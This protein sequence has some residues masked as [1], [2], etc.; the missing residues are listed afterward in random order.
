MPEGSHRFTVG[1]MQCT[2]LT[3]GYASYPTA[4]MFPGADAERVAQALASHRLPQETVLSPYTC[5]LIE[6][7]REALLVDTGAGSALPTSGALRARLEMV[8]LRPRDVDTV[9]LTHC[10]PDHL[11]GAVACGRPAFPN[12]R[13]VVAEA[14]LEFWQGPRRAPGDLRAPG[15]VQRAMEQTARS[16]LAA[17][18]FQ[19]EPVDREHEI[20]PGVRLIPA[21]GHTPGHLALLI[22]S[23]GERLLHIGDAAV[24]PLHLEEPSWEYGLDLAA[25][26]AL[27]T[28]RELMERAVGERMHVMAFHFPFPSVGRVEPR[29]E[30]G[31]RWTPGW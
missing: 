25:G 12:A 28:R 30:G 27:E 18:R 6:S 31:W 5:L 8:G 23:Q 10:H 9:V 14:E 3:D 13:Y 4:W 20:V 29:A 1:S 17:L 19:L 16:C 15:E 21:P 26:P 22:E 24:H 2:V 7:G 11:G